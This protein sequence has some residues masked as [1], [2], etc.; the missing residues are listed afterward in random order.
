MAK[1]PEF[2]NDQLARFGEAMGLKTLA[3][4]ERGTVGFRFDNG[5]A[6]R[7]EY[8]F[9]TLSILVTVP[10]EASAAAMERLLARSHYE[11]RRPFKVRTGY[12]EKSGCAF[13]ALRLR[14]TDVTLPVL[15]EVWNTLWREARDFGGAQ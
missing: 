8:A 1:A 3:L 4:S 12:L 10:C 11:A 13:F 15:Q 5:F 9:E 14:E 7:F 6:V 2:L